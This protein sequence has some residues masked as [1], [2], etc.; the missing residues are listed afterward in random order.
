[1]KIRTLIVD[2]E[3]LGRKRIRKLLESET[4]FEIVGESRDGREALK[5]IQSLAPALVFLDVQ[6]PELS[7]FDVLARLDP[8]RLPVIIFVTAYDDFALK[9]FEAQALDYLLKP[10]ADERFAQALQ[11]AKTFLDGHSAAAMRERLVSLVNSW[12]PQPK[13]LARVAVKTGERI[14]FLKIEAIDW[15]EAVGN[16]VNFHA[17]SETHLL[18]GG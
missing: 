6:M 17:G 18:R 10:F 8:E 11:R 5:S 2:D 7:G 13:Y 1:V 4:D 15:I 14:L 12:P 16:Y 9:A 3:P